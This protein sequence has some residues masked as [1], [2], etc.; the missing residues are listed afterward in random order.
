MRL[1]RRR[2]RVRAAAAPLILLVIAGCAPSVADD[3]TP[4]A[5][6]YKEFREAG[7]LFDCFPAYDTV[8]SAGRS[9]TFDVPSLR[10]AA[11][12]YSARNAAYVETI[13]R[14]A[15]PPE[16]APIAEELRKTVTA[17]IVNLDLLSG[18]SNHA[19]AYP[20]LNQVYYA[21]AAFN[22]ITDRLRDALD[23]PVP[24]AT[25]ALGQFELARQVAQKDT[26]TLQRLFDAALATGDLEA[27]RNVSRTQQT[28]L[29]QF[30]VSI[31]R[32]DFPDD[33]LTRVDDLRTKIDASIAY[34]RRQ[35][36]VPEARMIVPTP[37]EGGPEF[38]AREWAAA[39]ISEDLADVDPPQSPVPDCP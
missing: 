31:D 34:H 25:R 30:A 20:L 5:S 16:A 3:P 35:V 23:R 2:G 19:D 8:L 18:I 9:D 33:F 14:I 11:G 7:E 22:E 6:A 26:L 37:P 36:D 24:E 1:G 13:T 4:E 10:T 38:Q 39:G 12:E 15:F 32:I 28:L 21:E 27:A 29:R 17:E